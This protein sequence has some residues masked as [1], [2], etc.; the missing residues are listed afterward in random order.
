M[1]ITAILGTGLGCALMAVLIEPL[2]RHGT[3]PRA[4]HVVTHDPRIA[5]GAD[6]VVYLRD[7]G[8]F[9]AD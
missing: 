1:L 7:G 8:L 2:R 4:H 9:A 3:A 6:R 5:G